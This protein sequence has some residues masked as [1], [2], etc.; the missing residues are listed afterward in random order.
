[1]IWAVVLL[2]WISAVLLSL[3]LIPRIRNRS[4]P[5]GAKLPPMPPAK[6]IWGHVE[7]NDRGFHRTKALEWAKTYG[8][9]YRLRLNFTS[10][11]VLNDVRSIKRILN[12]T[13]VLNRAHG[14]VHGS[15]NYLGF[16]LLNGHLWKA[17]RKFVM[18]TLHDIGFATS[19]TE[20]KFK[21]PLQWLIK[22][23]EE[24][25]GQPTSVRQYIMPCVVANVV[26]LFFP[27]T[28]YTAGGTLQRMTQV[29]G[30]L[31]VPL[32][33]GRLFETTPALLR[34]VLQRLPFTRTGKACAAMH[35]YTDFIRKQIED[36][37]STWDQE[38]VKDFIKCCTERTE[39]AELEGDE[40]FHYR[41]LVGNVKDLI[42]G[43]TFSSTALIHWHLLNFAARPDTVQARVQ[44]EI[45]EVV[46]TERAPTWEDRQR[47]P[48]T[49]AC[50]WELI[51]WKTPSPLGVA[52]VT[53][54]DL[55]AEGVFIPK[56][57]VIVFNMWAVHNDT[58]YWKDPYCFN[59]CRFLNKDGSIVSQ[60]PPHWM[61]FSVGRRSCPGEVFATLEIFLLLTLVLQKFRVL[62]ET[63]LP[64]DL[65][66]PR[67][68]MRDV[69]NLKLRFIPR[70][71]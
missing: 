1:M 54:D 45:D 28:Q 65:D 61:P 64:Y 68:I 37:K 29:L 46:G 20:E 16:A 59:P 26:S 43:G 11:I 9:I 36:Y 21:V 49:L 66:D 53:S 5:P 30:K 60:K 12:R 31:P 8:P 3:V 50:I 40:T 19:S 10:V 32:F 63:P 27:P 62:L 18:S 48:Y 24:T 41:F 44:Q 13:Q 69:M 52:R 71:P 35:E 33:N 51:R 57:T 25:N 17:H 38:P 47:M 56:D 22:Q 2:T 14:V 55:V 4:L 34:N 67:I 7:L 23:L 6:S 70:R 39:R 42:M 15:D 58:S